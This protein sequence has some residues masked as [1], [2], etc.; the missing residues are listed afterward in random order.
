[1]TRAI[2]TTVHQPTRSVRR[3]CMVLGCGL[4]GQSSWT[5]STAWRGW[6]VAWLVCATHYGKLLADHDWQLVHGQAPSWHPWIL[7]G[8]DVSRESRDVHEPLLTA[9]SANRRAS[10]TPLSARQPR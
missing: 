1:M 7:M 2:R 9:E 6:P 3:Q 5:S 8:D 10:M 4:E